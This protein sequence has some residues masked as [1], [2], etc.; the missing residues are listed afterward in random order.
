MKKDH[1]TFKKVSALLIAES[2]LLGAFPEAVLANDGAGDSIREVSDRIDSSDID[3]PVI[4]N[5]TTQDLE[6]ESSQSTAA[7]DQNTE[8]TAVQPTEDTTL[9]DSQPVND[10]NTKDTIRQ[11]L[12]HPHITKADT[13]NP[14]AEP[15]TSHPKLPDDTKVKLDVLNQGE[16]QATTK[17]V[18][19]SVELPGHAK[20]DNGNYTW[21]EKTGDP[22][23]ETPTQEELSVDL[24]K[25]ELLNASEPKP[26]YDQ[27]GKEIAQEITY[28]YK[29]DENGNTYQVTHRKHH[30]FDE[31]GE[32]IPD[33]Q[34][35]PDLSKP[36]RPEN[37]PDRTPTKTT[38]PGEVV[39]TVT[40][41][42]VTVNMKT[43]KKK[44]N[45]DSKTPSTLPDVYGATVVLNGG[46]N[47][48]YKAN[49]TLHLGAELNQD[50]NQVKVKI[51]APGK[52]PQEVSF[53]YNPTEDGKM[54]YILQGVEIEEGQE[55]K[56]S[57]TGAQIQEIADETKEKTNEEKK[58]PESEP[59]QKDQ[60]TWMANFRYS[61]GQ[62][63]LGDAGWFG[64]FA[65]RYTADDPAWYPADEAFDTNANIAV[66]TLGFSGL[67]QIVGIGD[68]IKSHT[69]TD[70]LDYSNRDL[71]Y[72]GS[73][74]GNGSLKLQGN[75]NQALR[76]NGSY[77]VL[78]NGFTVKDND[79]S[80]KSFTATKKE[81][82]GT[83]T[84]VT[85]SSNKKENVL[86]AKN[87]IDFDYAMEKLTDYAK[88]LQQKADT[89]KLVQD[90]GNTNRFTVTSGT[91]QIGDSSLR[92]VSVGIDVLTDRSASGRDIV[93]QNIGDVVGKVL[94]NVTG[95]EN[96]DAN[97]THEIWAN[98][99]PNDTQDTWTA[100]NSNILFN[101]G[102][103][104]GNLNFTNKTW[105]GSVLAPKA[106]VRIASPQA[107]FNGKVIANSVTRGKNEQHAGG[108]NWN[109]NGEEKSGKNNNEE[110]V[111]IMT[112]KSQATQHHK[113]HQN[114][115]V[116]I[117]D[118][119]QSFYKKIDPEKP[120]EPEKPVEPTD[121]TEPTKPV[122]PTEP[123]DPTE[124]TKP[125]EPTN[126]TEPA[127][128]V[129]P[130]NPTEPT[131]PVEPTNPTEPAKP[132]EPTDPTE[133]T[134]PVEATNPTE[135]TKPVEPTTPAVPASSTQ[136]RGFKL[137][138]TA[139]VPAAASKTNT[140]AK[141]EFR[142]K[143]PKTGMKRSKGANT[144]TFSRLWGSVSAMLAAGGVGILSLFGL[145]SRKNQK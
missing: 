55:V 105:Y 118:F 43:E 26:V 14:A 89:D 34:L 115:K 144:A 75:E 100:N 53:Q 11:S 38:T 58:D 96:Y 90:Q 87:P 12:A 78:G 42:T 91:T 80:S 47:G 73:F 84:T 40:P 30:V 5:Q 107:P 2:L 139:S 117:A 97:A 52:E 121:P 3:L 126:P 67:R 130:T 31:K 37:E 99:R 36:S 45:T 94:V 145:K 129:E 69:G 93:F 7:T 21:T 136:W 125:V 140:P 133:P 22:K 25:L 60:K 88:S 29:L 81:D 111:V 66:G 27:D 71:S 20:E 48:Q 65:K 15:N 108:P 46:E 110:L 122:E 59:T 143:L 98:N 61:D 76:K 6:S 86:S 106:N 50:H 35:Q 113:K 68:H 134:K 24:S 104:A 85:I 63:G 135:P 101:F 141:H 123:T 62:S 127:K 83:E 102:D 1:S 51:L 142:V 114:H 128:P 70:N 137:P 82:N 23:T 131:K 120:T 116:E 79:G 16:A 44:E 17:F 49:I 13:G 138:E 28:T 109:P 33:H 39:H 4:T 56:L 64:V 103:Y 54:D 19:P 92:V 77:L 18:S 124:P 8:N 95:L 9:Q 119:M 57:L 74:D 112:V 41:G 72:V 32:R 10:Q 132:V